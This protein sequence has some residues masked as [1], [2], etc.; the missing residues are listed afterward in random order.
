LARRTRP[1]SALP[2]DMACSSSWLSTGD[3]GE[4]TYTSSWL[5]PSCGRV[6]KDAGELIP[7]AVGVTF[8]PRLLPRSCR[9]D[10]TNTP[11]S[12]RARGRS[13]RLAYQ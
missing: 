1:N 4:L 3:L 9:S 2:T 10:T 11:G 13:T 5:A 6:D 7:H 12:S 8:G